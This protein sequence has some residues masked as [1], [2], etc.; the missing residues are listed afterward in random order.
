MFGEVYP[1]PVRVVS[2]GRAV[3]ELLAHPTDAI[4][5]AFS[6]EFCGGTHLSNTSEA[7]AFALLSEEG[8]AKGIRRIVAVT[9]GDAVR[10]IETAAAMKAELAEIAKLQDDQLEKACK[11][12]K[13]VRTRMAELSHTLPFHLCLLSFHSRHVLIPHLS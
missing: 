4:N 1:D 5:S 11:R 2:I 7:E 8:I 10:A 3:E 6:I 9:R 13:E 12:F